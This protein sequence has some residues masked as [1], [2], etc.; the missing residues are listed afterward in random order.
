MSDSTITIL[1][2]NALGAGFASQVVVPVGTTISELF[3]SQ[4]GQDTAPSGYVAQVRRGSDVYGGAV[5]ANEP[6]RF[7]LAANFVLQSG[8]RVSITPHAMKG[9]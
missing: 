4:M 8:D 3:M 5:S 7:P 2:A 6:G 1:F 9:A